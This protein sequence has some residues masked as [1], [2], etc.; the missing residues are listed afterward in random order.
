MTGMTSQTRG[1]HGPP[2]PS[3]A[4]RGS[5]LAH[6]AAPCDTDYV[7]VF[8]T[9]CSVN[10]AVRNQGPTAPLLL[11]KAI[12]ERELGNYTAAL[13]S[14]IDCTAMDPQCAEAFHQVGCANL[15]LALAKVRA[16]AGSPATA[17]ACLGETARSFLTRATEAFRENSRLNPAD[18]EASRDLDVLEQI[19]AGCTAEGTLVAALRHAA[20]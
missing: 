14:A 19:A 1:F 7:A 12:L 9:L 4:L 13:T 11:R 8:T 2:Q 6:L 10:L 5:L 16:V 18:E 3:G 15:L 20:A 17:A